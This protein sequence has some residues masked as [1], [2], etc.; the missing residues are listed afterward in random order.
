MTRISMVYYWNNGRLLELEQR[1]LQRLQRLPVSLKSLALAAARFK[2][3]VAESLA[4]G[5]RQH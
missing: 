1:R 5:L 4:P 3:Q 2:F